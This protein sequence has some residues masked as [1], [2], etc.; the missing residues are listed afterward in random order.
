MFVQC[1]G[2]D[3]SQIMLTHIWSVCRL[4]LSVFCLAVMAACA[5]DAR[6]DKMIFDGP[7][8]SYPDDIQKNIR[9][10][11]V[12]GGNEANPLWSSQ[13]TTTAF[14][15]SLEKSLA[16]QRLLAADAELTLDATLLEI[17]EPQV[18]FDMEVA[19]TVL[20][21]LVKDTTGE[22][23]FNE[24]IVAPYIAGI[25]DAMSSAG[26]LRVASEG[27]V[28]ANIEL[29]LDKLTELDRGVNVSDADS[30]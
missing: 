10:N 20:Y 22:I 21:L 25:E 24:S 23:V 1:N 26:R 6:V 28:L 30:L 4:I 11:T 17:S 14:K 19:A 29:F 8:L 2:K 16:A 27:A 12:G 18:A 7:R 5:T 15:Q 9:I 13:I 3:V